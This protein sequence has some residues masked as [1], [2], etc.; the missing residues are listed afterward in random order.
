MVYIMK[1]KLKENK[2]QYSNAKLCVKMSPHVLYDFCSKSVD[3][4]GALFYH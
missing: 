3:T 4:A 1:E 2:S